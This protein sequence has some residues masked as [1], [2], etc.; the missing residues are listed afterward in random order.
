MPTPEPTPEPA[1]A[2]L[3]QSHPGMPMGCANAIECASL[4]EHKAPC[5][6]DATTGRTY[7]LP[8]GQ[9]LRYH[10]RK[11][12]ERGETMPATLSA[13]RSPP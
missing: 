1:H 10:R 7:C 9:R 4:V 13:V 2:M 3:E 12:L 11:A 8:C 5:F 6:R